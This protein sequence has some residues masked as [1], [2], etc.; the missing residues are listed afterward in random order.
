[1]ASRGL[2]AL[3]DQL[4]IATR[5]L[6]VGAVPPAVVSLL[7]R[8]V[9]DVEAFVS[10]LDE[11]AASGTI[12]AEQLREFKVAFRRMHRNVDVYSIRI[13]E[14]IRA[15]LQRYAA[16]HSLTESDAIR[17]VLDEALPHANDSQT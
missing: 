5:F 2:N 6:R 3:Q 4:G 17:K 16:L 9:K 11:R 15:R 10:I 1:M 14:D 7:A 13:P 8:S 12:N